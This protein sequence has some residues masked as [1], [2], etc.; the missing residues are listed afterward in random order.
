MWKDIDGNTIKDHSKIKVYIFYDPTSFSKQTMRMYRKAER[1]YGKGSVAL[2]DVTTEEGFSQ[3]WKA[4]ASEDIREINLNYH[5]SNQALHLSPSQS[6]YIT[7]TGNGK[8]NKM[9]NQALNVSDLPTISGDISNAHLN[10]N[11][12]HSNNKEDIL[13]GTKLTLMESFHRN[14]PF[15]TVRGTSHSVSYGR[16]LGHPKPGHSWWLFERWDY[17][18]SRHININTNDYL[19]YKTGGMK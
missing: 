10:I 9:H 17:L 19:Y 6:Q 11:S 13:T 12:C 14:F 5:G 8:T 2:S 4:M 15:K 1:K 7:S 16:I 3:D 18:P